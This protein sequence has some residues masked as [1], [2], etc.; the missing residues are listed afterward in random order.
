MR[1]RYLPSVRASRSCSH[2]ICSGGSAP[3]GQNVSGA[4][5]LATN[6]T[7]DGRLMRLGESYGVDRMEFLSHYRGNELDPAAFA[8]DH[9]PKG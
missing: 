1:A 2:L 7:Y 9:Y 5:N 4:T 8:P 6:A 3:T